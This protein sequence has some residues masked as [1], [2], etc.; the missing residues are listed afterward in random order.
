MT[1]LEGPGASTETIFHLGA[2][3]ATTERDLVALLD[4]NVA[5]RLPY[6]DGVRRRAPG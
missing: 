1:W 4:N 3:S 6:G 2:I 5:S